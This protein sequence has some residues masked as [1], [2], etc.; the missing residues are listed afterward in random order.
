M[1]GKT[2]YFANDTAAY[3]GGSFAASDYIRQEI[4]ARGWHCVTESDQRQIETEVIDRC[5]AVLVNG[6]GTLHRSKP[7]AQHLL[8]LLETAQDLGKLTCLCN[9]SWFDMCNDFDPILQRLDHFSVREPLSR[10]RLRDQHGV[11]PELFLDLSYWHP[12]E[13]GQAPETR[14][15]TTDLYAHEFDCFVH[16]KGGAISDLPF[17]DMRSLTWPE[18]LARVNATKVLITGRFHGLMAACRTRT[19]FIAYPGNTP[20]LDGVLEWFG[21]DLPLERDPRALVTR[22]RQSHRDGGFYQAFFDWVAE[23]E[24][25]RFPF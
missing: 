25:W 12:T 2:V 23:R 19:R 9:A 13:V 10:T 16:L 7:R 21:S 14:F 6:E 11:D 20:K 24:Q 4:A 8:R 17:L 18:T 3:H 1:T 22:M 5:D 15:L